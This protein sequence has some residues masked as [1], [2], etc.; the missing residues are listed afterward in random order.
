VLDAYDHQR[1]EVKDSPVKEF[2]IMDQ[3][4]PMCICRFSN[5]QQH[6]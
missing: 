1:K 5:G 6:H 3:Y 2:V 4:Q